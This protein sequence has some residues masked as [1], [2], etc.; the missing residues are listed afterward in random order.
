MKWNF[1]RKDTTMKKLLVL[2]AIGLIFISSGCEDE[3]TSGFDRTPP[4]E[5][6]GV[7]VING[8]GVV[9]IGWKANRERDLQGYNVYYSYSYNGRYELI[10]S[11]SNNYFIDYDAVNGEKIYYAVTAYDYDNNESELS[12][13]V[14]YTIPRPEGFNQSIFDYRRFPSNSGYDFS[15]YAVVSY[16]SNDADFFFENYEG[17]FYLDVWDDS[18]IQDMGPTTDIY[19][20]EAAPLSGWS[21]TKD[22]IAKIGHTYIIWTWDN[23]FAKIRIRNITRDRVVFDW[24]YQLVEGSSILKPKKAGENRGKL[25]RPV[26]RGA[27][28]TTQSSY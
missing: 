14:V 9:D 1:I 28:L 8:D 15:N 4:A 24:A 18:D 2:F 19:D 13:D 11:T 23:H 26:L 12:R 10:G 7:Y 17:T 20:I 3:Y 5:P 27:E 6:S 16:N 25:T 21:P 22:E